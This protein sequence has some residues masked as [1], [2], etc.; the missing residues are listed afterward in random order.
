MALRR[1]IFGMSRPG[2]H[3]PLNEAEI[4]LADALVPELAARAGRAAHERALQIRGKVT[5]VMGANLVEKSASGS[6]TVLRRIDEPVAGMAG[7]VLR[8]RK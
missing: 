3:P 1:K 5:M 4:Q 6:I 7:K 8:R 2:N